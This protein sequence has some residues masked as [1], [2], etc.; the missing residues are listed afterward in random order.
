M[1]V[2]IDP[3]MQG[4]NYGA[5]WGE[6]PKPPVYYFASKLVLD[7][8]RQAG[9]IGAKAWDLEMA[10]RDVRLATLGAEKSVAIARL[11]AKLEELTKVA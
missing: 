7:M 2:I 1:T 3:R 5:G 9:E 10:I 4:F 6:G 11:E 8:R